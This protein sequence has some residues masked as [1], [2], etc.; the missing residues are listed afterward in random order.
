MIRYGL[1]S[2]HTVFMT[3]VVCVYELGCCFVRVSAL[4]IIKIV[5][6]ILNHVLYTD[7]VSAIVIAVTS[8]TFIFLQFVALLA[9]IETT[10]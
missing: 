2:I 9:E 10:H 3:G 6:L 4:S 8:F 1:F 5:M 7:V